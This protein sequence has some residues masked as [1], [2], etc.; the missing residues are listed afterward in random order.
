MVR[1]LKGAWTSEPWRLSSRL[2]QSPWASMPTSTHLSQADWSVRH[3]RSQGTQLC[4]SASS[5]CLPLSSPGPSCWAA[6]TA[7]R[8]RCSH[9]SNSWRRSLLPC[10]SARAPAATAAAAAA[11]ARQA[12]SGWKSCAFSRVTRVDSAVSI[13]Q[14]HGRLAT[15]TFCTWACASD[16]A[17]IRNLPSWLPFES[18]WGVFCVCVHACVHLCMHVYISVYEYI[19]VYMC[20]CECVC[21]CMGESACVPATSRFVCARQAWSACKGY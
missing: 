15:V 5:E 19:H 1:H 10:I 8:R 6:A 13:Q 9:C 11:A 20:V 4:S 3:T 21:V 7:D 16:S 17:T 18:R 2:L 14:V 12:A